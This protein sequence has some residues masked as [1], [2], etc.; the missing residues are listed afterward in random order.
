MLGAIYQ[1][2]NF[3]GSPV[4][5]AHNLY[6]P[7]DMGAIDIELACYVRDHAPEKGGLGAYGHLRRAHDLLF[8]PLAKTWF[9]W[10]ED[11]FKAAASGTPYISLAGARGT[12]KTAS[13]AAFALCWL[14]ASPN[15]RIVIACSTSIDA[16]NDRFFRYIR[17]YKQYAAGMPGRIVNHPKPA[18]FF[19]DKETRSS[20]IVSKAIK[21][22]SAESIA[23]EFVGI[24]YEGGTL[25]IVD[26]GQKLPRNATP[27]LI[28]AVSNLEKKGKLQVIV[29]GNPQDKATYHG[30]VSAPLNGTFDDL[31]P[32][33]DQ[34]WPTKV[35]GIC[36]RFDGY[37]SPALA[38]PKKYN[39]LMTQEEIDDAA[40]KLGRDHPHFLTYIRGFWPKIS[41]EAT[42]LSEALIAKFNARLPR[43]PQAEHL[44]T[45]AGLDPAFTQGGDEC[46]LQFADLYREPSGFLVLD[47]GGEDNCISIPIDGQSSEPPFYQVARRTKELCQ[48]RSVSP[49]AF[50]VET[51]GTGLGLGSIMEKEWHED[52]MQICFAGKPSDDY[53]GVDLS[54]KSKDVYDRRVTE[55][56]FQ[57]RAYVEANKI[58]GLNNIAATEFCSR[59]YEVISGKHKLETKTNYKLRSFGD[60][61]A[62]GSPDRADACVVVL[63][64]AKTRFNFRIEHDDFIDSF[65]EEQYGVQPGMQESLYPKTNW[66]TRNE[67]SF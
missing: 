9:P 41:G 36:L 3:K 14:W 24:H 51:T 18:F 21:P 8:P 44:I 31:D 20:G 11:F 29:A 55:L 10:K 63:D 50:A 5:K 40:K 65:Y 43:H 52:I 1:K 27:G 32:D 58:R 26:E 42:I 25:L 6:W 19:G 60:E 33:R 53:T 34:W 54:T 59:H 16:M 46:I 2:F 39:F 35:G 15:N 57:V 30:Y 12:A 64:L 45:L 4:I 48:K 17:N 61:A 7:E 49:D 62:S 47:Y 38:D 37:R 13:M 66:G 56:W 23:S 28:E 67:S 22:G